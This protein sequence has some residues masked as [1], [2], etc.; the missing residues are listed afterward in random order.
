MQMKRASRA[1]T[2]YELRTAAAFA[3]S[4][5][6]L[7]LVSRHFLPSDSYLYPST[8]I[9][10]AA[11][12][13]GGGRLTPVVFFIALIAALFGH[14]SI[15]LSLAISIAVALQAYAGAFA[16][17]WFGIDP[18]FRK[19]RDIF[20]LLGSCAL[21]ALIGPSI[22]GITLVV[23]G[24]PFFFQEWEYAYVANVFCFFLMLPFLMRWLTKPRF[25]RTWPEIVETLVPFA[26]IAGIC[27]LFVFGVR[28][29][30]GISLSYLLL[31]PFFGSLSDCDRG[32][33]RSL[34]LLPPRSS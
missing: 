4:Y 30:L 16:L 27:V 25:K 18:L 34:F 7:F 10:I 32:S 23:Q 33:S 13:F 8:S 21:V 14:L 5:L 26:L 11:V 17:R 24:T 31:A 29:I 19:S 6:A 1:Y 3:V 28:G 20:I 2:R 22:V 9:A 15:A 12:Y